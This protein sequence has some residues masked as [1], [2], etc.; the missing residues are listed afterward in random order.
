MK[1]F[2]LFH[3]LGLVAFLGVGCATMHEGERLPKESVATIEGSYWGSLRYDKALM[4]SIDEKDFGFRPVAS[5]IILPG[6][7][8]VTVHC[9]HG[10]SHLAGSFGHDETLELIAVA[11]HKY[12]AKC[13][14]IGGVMG[15][16]WSWIEDKLTG[17]V[18]AGQRPD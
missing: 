10:W 6:H 17:E 13:K 18:V 2:R 11:G 14:L 3:I 1:V 15:T 16:Q 4:E 7:H 8:S 5:A 12:Q 9:Y